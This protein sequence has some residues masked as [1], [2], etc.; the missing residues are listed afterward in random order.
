MPNV[1][2]LILNLK[3]L[4]LSSVV[5]ILTSSA[6]ADAAN[7]I[8][9][10]MNIK[11]D[12][13]ITWQRLMYAEDQFISEV[14]YEDY[15][16]HPQ[17]RQDLK[18]ELIANIEQL[19]LAQADNASIRCKFPARSQFL[20]QKLNI[21]EDDLPQV[22][23]S[24][25]EEWITTIQPHKAVFIYATD[26]MGNPSSMFGHTLLRIDPKDQQQL[27]LVSYAINYAATVPDE[28]S[29][30][31]AW[32][33]L[34]GQYPGEYSL[35]PYYLKVKEY[36]DFESRD[37]WEYELNLTPKEV[38]F[39]VAHLWE[40]KQVHFPYYFISDN[41]AYR[42]LGLMD[43]LRPELKL[44]Q[45]FK[46]VS[47]PVETLKALDQAQLIG[48]AVYRPALETQL[49]AQSHQH[50]LEL[51]K[52][53][54]ALSETPLSEI[55]N[56]LHDFNIQQQAQILE[57][58]Y[59]YL[60]LQLLAQK[61]EAKTAQVYLRRFLALRSLL[62]IEKQRPMIERP[63]DE[64]KLGHHAR[65][66]S[67]TTG[68]VQSDIVFELGW[69]AAYHDLRDPIVG[70]RTGTQLKFM[71]FTLQKRD[72]RLKLAHF[73][74]LSVHSYHPMSAF[75]TPLSWGF[76][77]NWQQEAI[78]HG[79]Y[80]PNKQHGVM[81]LS[82]QWG[83]TFADNQRHNICFMKLKTHVQAGKSLD[84]GWR[85][86]LGP[87]FGCQLQANAAFGTTLKMQLPYWHDQQQWQLKTILELQYQKG[88]QHLFGLQS[89]FEQ[90][91][92]KRWDAFKLKYS[93]FY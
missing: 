20:R 53:A 87:L 3:Q 89:Y 32:K 7:A 8:A 39:L 14:A 86:G 82:T 28:Q 4:L 73:D 66:L 61:V 74:V 43:V 59:D 29:W 55:V 76:D 63:T 35:M 91:N 46:Y 42:L 67:L 69:R 13:D 17:G 70:Y 10:A 88:Q 5:G 9:H 51:A 25:F 90:Q 64:P 22:M 36:G 15:F 81:N 26:F 50:G 16:Y 78:G 24:E 6:Y 71:D 37:L 38:R 79:I 60:Y 75:K 65:R 47:I 44:K 41:C 27:N 21:Y 83:Y 31:Y 57:M 40:M 23:C 11:L 68:Q 84:N 80:M 45:Q 54:R 30:S 2:G 33:G 77:L 19:F 72:N 48:S 62:N 34:T 93:Y 52:V 56:V 58:A 18:Q 1:L 49:L 85:M 92:G 12:Q